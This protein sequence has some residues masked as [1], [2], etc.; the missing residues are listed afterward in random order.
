MPTNELWLLSSILIGISATL[1]VGF[2]AWRQTRTSPN[3][4]QYQFTHGINQGERLE[5]SIAIKSTSTSGNT[6]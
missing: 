5:I 3:K 4:N 2:Y 6:K 1:I